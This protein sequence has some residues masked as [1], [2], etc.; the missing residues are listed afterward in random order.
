MRRANENRLQE[1]KLTK[2]ERQSKQQA[3]PEEDLLRVDINHP[4]HWH[5]IRYSNIKTKLENLRNVKNRDK[6]WNS[7][8]RPEGVNIQRKKNSSDLEFTGEK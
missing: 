1:S 3:L 6:I 2:E 8:M 7:R 4:F 5:I